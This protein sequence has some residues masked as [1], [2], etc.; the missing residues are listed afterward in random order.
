[1]TDA[2]RAIPR[3]DALLADARFADAVARLGT[4]RVKR[5]ITRAQAEA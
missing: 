5:A 2:R 3:T 1:M 4:D